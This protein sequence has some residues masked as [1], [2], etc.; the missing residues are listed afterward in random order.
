MLVY[1]RDP[2]GKQQRDLEERERKK[3]SWLVFVHETTMFS[4]IPS[5]DRMPAF[6]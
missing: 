2:E 1:Q 4:Y 3:K 6:F 5:F